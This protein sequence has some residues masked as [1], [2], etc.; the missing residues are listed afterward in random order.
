MKYNEKLQKIEL[1]EVSKKIQK[2]YDIETNN[3]SFFDFLRD[4]F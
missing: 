1:E 4:N 2:E 3:Y